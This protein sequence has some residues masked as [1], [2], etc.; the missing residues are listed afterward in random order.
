[1]LWRVVMCISLLRPLR[2]LCSYKH[3]R[4]L[5]L[6]GGVRMTSR[7]LKILFYLNMVYKPGET[8]DSEDLHICRGHRDRL[9][10]YLE[11]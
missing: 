1:M 7:E 4:D 11:T 5:I 3:E 10:A 8:R 2:L 6:L 9:M